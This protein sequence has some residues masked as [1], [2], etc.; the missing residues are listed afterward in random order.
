MVKLDFIII[1]NSGS[2]K[3]CLVNCYVKMDDE[4]INASN[5]IINIH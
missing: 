3:T 5:I 4:N 1:G 2:G